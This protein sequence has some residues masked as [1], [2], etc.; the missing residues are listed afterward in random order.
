MYFHTKFI[1]N[2]YKIYTKFN[3]IY[4]KLISGNTKM[5]KPMITNGNM[6][7]K[8]RKKKMMKMRKM[9]KRK[10]LLLKKL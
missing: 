3:K 1:L 10:V 9:V 2:L 4:A 5:K 7:L 8:M 6:K